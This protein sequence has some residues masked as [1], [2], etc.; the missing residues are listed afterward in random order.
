MHVASAPPRDRIAPIT[1][2]S[3]AATFLVLLYTT[4]KHGWKAAVGSAIVGAAVGPM[5]FELPFD[6]IVIGRVLPSIPPNPALYK[7]L[8]FLPLFIVE[9]ST[10]ALLTLA[11][12]V[13]VSKHSLYCL[14]GMFFVFA[15]WALLGF[16]YPN[17]PAAYALNAM[18]KVLSFVTAI[19]LFLA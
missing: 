6:L 13:K 9:I 7:Q 16:H 10:M 17:E 15:V 3:A 1:V 5:I 12:M 11:P 19:T 14:A 18:S 4:R 2:L 8:F